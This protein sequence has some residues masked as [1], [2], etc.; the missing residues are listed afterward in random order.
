MIKRKSVTEEL[1]G[2]ATAAIQ[3]LRTFT[4]D[5]MEC[6]HGDSEEDAETDATHFHVKFDRK[7]V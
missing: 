7:S 5:V 1:L 6:D 4:D 3:K 2:V